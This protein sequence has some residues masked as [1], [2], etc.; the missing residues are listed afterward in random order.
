MEIARG[1]NCTLDLDELK[2]EGPKTGSIIFYIDVEGATLSIGRGYVDYS[3]PV[4][5]PMVC[6]NCMRR[7]RDTTILIKSFC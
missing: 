6:M 5:S 3:A 1:E 2:G 7:Q 4:Y